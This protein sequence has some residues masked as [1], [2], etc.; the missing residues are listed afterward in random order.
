MSDP[1]VPDTEVLALDA[2]DPL[3]SF[4]DAF[5]APQGVIYLDGNSLGQ[6]P[7][8]A[9]GRLDTVVREEWGRGLIRS[10]NDAGWIGAQA[11]LGGKI[12]G[13][14]GA[15]P[16]EVIVSDST[17]ANLY[18][19]VV[20]A[21]QARPGRA[22]VLSEPGDFP[23]DL[24]MIEGALRTM[25]GGRRL[26]LRA[27]ADIEAALNAEVGLLVLCHSHYKTA[28]VRQM[29]ELTR[30]G[31]AAGALVLWDLSHS[32]GVLEVDLNGCNADLAVGCTYKYLNG[33]PGSP[34]Y[35][36][37]ARRHQQT[38]VSPL[39]GWMGH[40]RPFD[41]VDHYE[42]GGGIQRFACGTP[43][44]LSLAGLE[45]GVDLA[46][47]AGTPRMAAKARALGDLFIRR[48]DGLEGVRLA[49]PRD[50]SLRGGH[51]SLSHPDGYAIMQAL[52]ARGVIG[53]FREP[54]IMRFGFSPLPLSFAEVARAAEI[55][56]DVL[57]TRAYDDPIYRQR[58]AVT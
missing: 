29:R 47:E 44:M 3:A 34:A 5:E 17:S 23:T 36:F 4:R 11:R 51:V 16:D 33:G 13:L 39:S 50:P 8:A 26:E 15:E 30:A 57:A 38:L 45:P 48:T 46:L 7:K 18:K 27:N 12:A 54:D 40:A 41:F 43:P 20:A 1:E 37:V 25:G 31:Q 55:L 42:A 19:L 21:M 28:A 24:Y 14:I 35:L 32:G 2:A 10:W 9:V 56:A 52:I 22:V 58:S 6:L 53:D 49:S